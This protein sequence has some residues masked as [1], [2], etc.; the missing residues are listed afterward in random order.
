MVSAVNP[1]SNSSVVFVGIPACRIIKPSIFGARL[2]Q[3]MQIHIKSQT[4]QMKSNRSVI[5]ALIEWDFKSVQTIL[6]RR[7]RVFKRRWHWPAIG[8]IQ[9]DFYRGVTDTSNL[10]A[11]Y[12]RANA[13]PDTSRGIPE[14][15]RGTCYVCQ[16]DVDFMVD[17]DLVRQSNNWR[18]TL[19]C[20]GCGLI[21]RWRSSLHLFEALVQPVEEDNVYVTEAVTSL[22]KTIASRYPRSVGSEYD[23]DVVPGT[24]IDLPSGPTRI[25]DVTGLTFPDGSFEAVL[26]FDV[27][28]HVPDFK[29]ALREFYRVLVPGG[30][31]LISVPFTFDDR[32]LTRAEVDSDG[33]IRHI[34]EPHYH[35]DPLSD[36]GVLCYYEFGLEL[37]REIRDAGFQEAF[38]V[39][40]TSLQWAYYGDQAIFVGR[41]SA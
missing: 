24:E 31:A 5:R 11:F 6:A 8:D 29:S 19:K 12:A 38:L 30:Q 26:S 17:T 9:G 28:E 3:S 13:R 35:G 25:E 27:L 7:Y 37:L 23:S 39:C 16:D 2:S 20:P 34:M 41:K 32:T 1:A 18:E 21:N 4:R 14:F 36:E 40:Y 15:V 10:R 22:F 33:S